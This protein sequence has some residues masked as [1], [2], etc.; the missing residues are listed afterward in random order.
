MR[1]F[2]AY[3]FLLGS[4]G[5]VLFPLSGVIICTMALI[6]TLSLGSGGKRLIEKDLKAIGKNRILIG[7]AKMST[8][9]IEIVERFPFVEYALFPEERYENGGNIFIGYS[10]K[11]LRTLGLNVPREKEVVVDKEQNMGKDLGDSIKLNTGRGT[12]NFVIRGFYKEE[13]PLETMRVGKR[14]ILERESFKREFG[15]RDYSS[16]VV[17]FPQDEDG[18][19]YIDLVLRELN[20]SRLKFNQIRLLETPE[21]YKKVERIMNFVNKSLF[22]LSFISLIV[23]GVGVLNLIGVA[24][25]NRG[26]SIGILR[27]MGMNKKTIMEIFLLEGFIVVFL[28]GVLGGVLGIVGSMIVGSIL[29]ILPY[30][31]IID[32]LMSLIISMGVSLLFGVYPAKRA[33][34]QSVV[35]ALKN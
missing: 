26:S 19:E 30:F 4:K 18:V 20:R 33:S 1:F 35:E 16:L 3:R 7:G 2:M 8:R 10:K 34:E 15:G 31:S 5:R 27:A 14:V 9:D 6:M 32:I 17:S 21:V 25:K 11:A 13:N 28:G 24:V 22:I 12:K 23:G 29:N